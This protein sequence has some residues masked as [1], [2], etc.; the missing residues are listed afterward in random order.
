MH[1]SV[2]RVTFREI[3]TRPMHMFDTLFLS[4]HSLDATNWLAWLCSARMHRCCWH[5]PFTAW[6]AGAV[7]CR[8]IVDWPPNFLSFVTQHP[9]VSIPSSL[10]RLDAIW[11]WINSFS[12]SSP[13]CLAWSMIIPFHPIWWLM[14]LHPGVFGYCRVLGEADGGFICLAILM[15]CSM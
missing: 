2:S 10:L 9:G 15:M 8:M 14:T 3:N 12:N 5:C 4:L 1:L 6:I 7:L 13:W 11:M